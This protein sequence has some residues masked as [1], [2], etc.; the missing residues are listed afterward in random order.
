MAL[1]KPTHTVNRIAVENTFWIL[2]ALSVNR[3]DPLNPSIEMV[4]YGFKNE[5]DYN[6]NP[7]DPIDT[8]VRTLSGDVARQAIL[9]NRANLLAPV[10]GLA[11]LDPFFQGAADVERTVLIEQSAPDPVH[12]PEPQP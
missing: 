9:Q 11:K 7:T 6:S 4:Y 2:V 1:Q 5:A 10:Y 12:E 8:R 3:R